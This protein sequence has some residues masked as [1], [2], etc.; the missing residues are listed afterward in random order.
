MPTTGETGETGHRSVKAQHGRRLMPYWTNFATSAAGPAIACIFT[1]PADVAKTRLNLELELKKTTM[2]RT[3]SS[4]GCMRQTYAAEGMAGLQRGLPLAMAREASKNTFRI[5][6]YQPILDAVHTKEGPVPL[7]T[8]MSAA[9][10]SGS[11]SAMIC[12]PFDLLKTRLQLDATHARGASAGGAI[13]M[14]SE[15]FREEGLRGLWRGTGVS[16]VR[17]GVGAAALLPTN[18]KLKGLSAQWV[19]AGPLSDGFCALG[20]GAANVAVINPVDVVR[21]RLYSQPLDASG[22]GRLYGGALDAAS[23]IM[24][25]EG[26]PA[27][28]KGATA[29]FL[30]VGPHTMLTFIFIGLLRR[31]VGFRAAS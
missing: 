22:N 8:M 28:Y 19:P 4:L 23:K 2:S 12:N 6:L 25:I 29:H 3:T 30:R 24:R 13:A 11:I 7:S 1:N 26:V 20:A 18:S 15:I 9:A 14:A 31:A 21:T 10:V 5:G 27:F 17:S 16:M